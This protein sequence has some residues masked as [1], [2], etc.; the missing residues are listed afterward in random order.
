MVCGRRVWA[1]VLSVVLLCGDHGPV[2][3]GWEAASRMS[4]DCTGAGCTLGCAWAGEAVPWPG[5]SAAKGSIRGCPAAVVGGILDASLPAVVDLEDAVVGQ[6]TGCGPVLQG[7]CDVV[8]AALLDSHALACQLDVAGAGQR[9][10]SG[11]RAVA[12]DVERLVVAAAA[13]VGEVPVDVL[14]P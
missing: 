2:G 14:Q 13:V 4:T 9:A 1:V 10:D 12:V 7:G 6:E 3:I 5:S 11:W 8:I